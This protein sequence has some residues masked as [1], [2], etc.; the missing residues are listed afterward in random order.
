MKRIALLILA[1]ATITLTA[2]AQQQKQGKKGEMKGRSSTQVPAHHFNSNSSAIPSLNDEQK[3]GL[4]M[5]RIEMAK[6]TT[7]TRNQIA[8]KR[9]RLNTL[10]AEDKVDIN[11][12]NKAIDDAYDVIDDLKKNI[13]EK[14]EGTENQSEQ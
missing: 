7:S 11:A 10:Q 5:L 13:N 2:Q 4:K 3:E 14:H 12:V 6:E 8:E 1:L 9:A